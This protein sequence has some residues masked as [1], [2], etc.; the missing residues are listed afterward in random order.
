[1]GD[2]PAIANAA[3]R[4]TRFEPDLIEFQGSI[5]S[6]QITKTYTIPKERNGPYC[7][8]LDIRV[9]G[10]ARGLWLSSGV[11]DVEIVS[12]SYSPLFRI[13]VTKNKL[14]GGPH[15]RSTQKRGA[16]SCIGHISPN[17][18]SNCNGFLGVIMDPLDET[19]AGYQTV[20][21]D[22]ISHSHTPHPHRSCL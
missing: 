7:F 4:M 16:G 13:Q 2:D 21:I 9:D 20:Q 8:N 6:A 10:D 12:N 18:I 5:G 19:L 14:S 15:D 11:P 3:Y 17:W 1:M 22:G